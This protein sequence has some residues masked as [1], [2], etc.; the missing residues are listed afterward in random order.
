MLKVRYRTTEGTR[1][2]ALSVI[3]SAPHAKKIQCF[4]ELSNFK[5]HT[6]LPEKHNLRYGQKLI[7]FEEMLHRGLGSSATEGDLGFRFT[8]LGI[9]ESVCCIICAYI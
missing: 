3:C 6:R 4:L 9:L 5:L 7:V 2:H 8:G 1:R